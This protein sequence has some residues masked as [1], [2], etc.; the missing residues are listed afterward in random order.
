MVTVFHKFGKSSSTPGGGLTPRTRAMLLRFPGLRGGLPWNRSG[1]V[2]LDESGELV[3]PAVRDTG[4]RL[5]WAALA[6]L[7]AAAAIV[8]AIRARR[9]PRGVAALLRRVAS[10]AS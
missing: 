3:G 5:G 10:R 8:L 4:L 9:R 1:A 6:G 2:I 7:G